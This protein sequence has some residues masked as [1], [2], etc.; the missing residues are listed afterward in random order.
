MIIFNVDSSAINS[1]TKHW[2]FLFNE[3]YHICTIYSINIPSIY[4]YM[5]QRFFPYKFI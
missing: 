3:E 2:W 5:T 4:L 1:H